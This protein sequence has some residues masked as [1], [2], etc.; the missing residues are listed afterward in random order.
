M[1]TPDIA[2]LEYLVIIV[3]MS[4]ISL[5]QLLPPA[6]R[7]LFKNKTILFLSDSTVVIS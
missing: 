7:K 5:F 1:E 4:V 3:A 6:T 2:Y